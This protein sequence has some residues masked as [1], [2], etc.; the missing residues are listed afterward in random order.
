MALQ[1]EPRPDQPDV[2]VVS[3]RLWR[4]VLYGLGIEMCVLLVVL[5]IAY[6]LGWIG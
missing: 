5:P 2:P 3:S 6:G 1:W 4:G